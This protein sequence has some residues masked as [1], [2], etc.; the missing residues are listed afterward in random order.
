MYLRVGGSA[1]GFGRLCRGDQTFNQIDVLVPAKW[2][3]S[4]TTL[5]R[6]RRGPG[7]HGVWNRLGIELWAEVGRREIDELASQVGIG[8][9][10]ALIGVLRN[11]NFVF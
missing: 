9:Q 1:K 10:G 3:F 8:P 5:G 2:I 6:I 4:V 7:A 11:L